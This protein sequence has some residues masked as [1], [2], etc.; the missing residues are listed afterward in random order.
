MITH[1]KHLTEALARFNPD[2]RLEYQLEVQG[3]SPMT[4][5]NITA[6]ELELEIA[7]LKDEVRNMQKKINS[8]E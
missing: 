4:Q 2:A 3:P 6:T 5:C 7:E 8:L 1:V